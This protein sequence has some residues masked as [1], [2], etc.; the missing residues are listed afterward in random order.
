[1]GAGVCK[2]IARMRVKRIT[3]V[4][5]RDVRKFCA[6]LFPLQATTIALNVWFRYTNTPLWRAIYI[7][8]GI[9]TMG[10]AAAA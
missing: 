5:A 9:S 1:M 10:A 6:H 4:D 7:M 2:S 3:E 8:F